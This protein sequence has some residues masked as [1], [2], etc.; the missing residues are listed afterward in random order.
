MTLGES[1]SSG[2]AAGREAFA[3][4]GPARPQQRAR[5]ARERF[6]AVSAWVRPFVGSG[7][8]SISSVTKACHNFAVYLVA[9]I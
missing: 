9:A 1:P 3:V 7:S 5:F 2:S 4:P 8:L 6:G